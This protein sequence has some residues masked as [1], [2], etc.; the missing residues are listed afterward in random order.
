MPG[1]S[2]LLYSCLWMF[3]ISLCV[4][5][6]STPLAYLNQCSYISLDDF[7]PQ[8]FWA[9]WH[10]CLLRQM[11]EGKLVITAFQIH[12]NVGRKWL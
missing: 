4:Q 10:L 3:V 11:S 9:A 6:P 7:Y 12:L 2:S 8:I 5:F 1:K